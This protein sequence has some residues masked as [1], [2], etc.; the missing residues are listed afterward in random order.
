M[1][2]SNKKTISNIA[3]VCHPAKESLPPLVQSMLKWTVK[4][5]ITARLSPTMAK[6]VGMPELEFDDDFLRNKAEMFVVLGGDGTILTVARDYSQYNLPIAGINLGHLGFMTLEEPNNGLYALKQLLAG[7]YNIET[8]SMLRA[9]VYRNNEKIYSDIALNDVVIQKAPMLR[10]IKINVSISGS[11]INT[12]EGDGII[13]STP[14]GSTAYS[15][16]AGGPI[17]PPWV[18]VMVVCPL[19]SHTLSARPV[20]VAD[21]ELLSCRIGC[22]HSNVEI[23]LDGHSNFKLQNNDIVEIITADETAQIVAFK[24]RDFFNVLRKK[25]NW[26]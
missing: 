5:H 12:Y 25:M 13:V 1:K 9:T 22:V 2:N 6:L 4:N 14:T 26:G 11:F 15:L 20:V 16:S 18:Q 23:V 3:F 7:N 10:I 17:V 8:R 24:E 21:D 19:N